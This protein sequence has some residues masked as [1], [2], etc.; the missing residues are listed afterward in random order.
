MPAECTGYCS[1][2]GTGQ[3][4][5]CISNS[6]FHDLQLYNHQVQ[7]LNSLEILRNLVDQ[8]VSEELYCRNQCHY[9]PPDISGLT[10]SS[11]R[12]KH[13]HKH[14]LSDVTWDFGWHGLWKWS[15]IRV[16]FASL[17]L[18][19]HIMIYTGPCLSH[20]PVE[21]R[22]EPGVWSLDRARR[23]PSQRQAGPQPLIAR[24]G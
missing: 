15:R 20:W 14:G 18:S 21:P 3:F 1:G 22:S 16:L 13:L 17:S 10:I 19:Q 7:T 11:W 5:D 24:K 2:A 4:D 23:Q 12:L 9:G 8:D 6:P